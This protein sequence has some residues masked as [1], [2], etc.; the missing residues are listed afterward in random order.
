MP[1]PAGERLRCDDCGAEIVFAKACPCPPGETKTHSDKCC[2]KEMRVLGA[3]SA[4]E[5]S[6]PH[7]GH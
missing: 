6:Q 3:I 5:P 4:A 7:P 1:H 2:G